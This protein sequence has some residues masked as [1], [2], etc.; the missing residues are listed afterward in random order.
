M[1][2]PL[3]DPVHAQLNL[4]L[5]SW[6]RRPYDTYQGDAQRVFE[7]L[8]ENLAAG[9]ILLMHDGHAART[10]DG[11]PVILAVLPRLLQKIGE[12]RLTPVTLP[13]ALT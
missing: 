6:T 4:Q 12:L 8:V 11:E 1:R 13:A 2:N 7:R 10:P 9:D 5:A 3:L